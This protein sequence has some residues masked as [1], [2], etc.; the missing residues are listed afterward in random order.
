LQTFPIR[1]ILGVTP[2]LDFTSIW[3]IGQPEKESWF[4]SFNLVKL[5]EIE[6]E[7][8]LSYEVNH[9]HS[10]VREKGRFGGYSPSPKNHAQSLSDGSERLSG[11]LC[12][13][14]IGGMKKPSH[15]TSQE[16]RDCF[17]LCR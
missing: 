15:K 7:N 17:V 3:I 1:L 12:Y 4:C 5:N 2:L 6:K 13:L 16:A 9:P 8:K 10:S 14:F 11:A